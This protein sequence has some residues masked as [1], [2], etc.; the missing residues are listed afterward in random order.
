MGALAIAAAG[1]LFVLYPA[2]R[3]FSDEA[4]LQGAAAFA[5]PEWTAAHMMA[6]VAF[7]LLP[8]GLLGLHSALRESSIEPLA[9]RAVVW[10]VLGTGL[11]LPFYGAETFGLHAIG[12][13]AFERRD[14]DL[15]TLA[16]VVRSGPGLV[17][18]VIGLLVLAV[19]AIVVAITVW[20]SGTYPRWAGI[21]FALG[22]A[23]YLPQFVFTQ[24]IRVAHGVLLAM[25]CLWLGAGLWRQA[26]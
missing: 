2:I 23:L 14:V 6:M 8:V 11:T 21:P 5:S 10:N 15:M 24:P 12:R 3:P 25:G 17:M 4:S 26:K 18:F 9:F 7:T 13:A 19:S 16:S 1:I 20:R 22:L